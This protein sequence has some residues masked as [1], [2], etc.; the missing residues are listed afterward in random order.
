MK[1]LA[2]LFFIFSFLG[3]SKAQIT[4][5][6]P[7]T[8]AS[9]TVMV[10]YYD[11][12]WNYSHNRYVA[13]KDTLIDT[14]TYYQIGFADDL[15]DTTGIGFYMYRID[16]L[17]I[18]FR[19]NNG[20]EFLKYDF[21]MQIGDSIL[22]YPG[23]G[24]ARLDSIDNFTIYSGQTLT[25]YLLSCQTCFYFTD[26]IWYY[27]IGSLIAP[28]PGIHN[29]SN[30]TSFYHNNEC[31]LFE[32]IF[33]YDSALCY[34]SNL[35]KIDKKNKNDFSIFPNPSNEKFIIEM[36]NYQNS[37]YEIH[38]LNG[39]LILSSKIIS[40]TTEINITDKTGVFILRIINENGVS[41]KKIILTE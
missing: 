7:D 27:G 21:G 12:F 18:Y 4:T 20:V 8:T 3:N 39:K 10:S 5:P 38:D 17:K 33:N 19:E 36:D 15:N 22:A 28:F 1:N 32:P 37:N 24:Y 23:D 35:L 41:I 34:S 30:L 6:F 13:V 31:Y 16:S 26:A 25:R 14:L 40:E 2:I 11:N 29:Q 9:W